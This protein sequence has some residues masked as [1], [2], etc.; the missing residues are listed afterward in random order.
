MQTVYLILFTIINSILFS[1]DAYFDATSES[2]TIDTIEPIIEVFTPTDGQQFYYGQTTNI[3]WNA[4][5]DSEFGNNAVSISIQPEL[6]VELI[7]LFYDIP[8]TGTVN[9]LLPSKGYGGIYRFKDSLW[10]QV[11]PIDD[12]MQRIKLYLLPGN[13]KIV[14]RSKSAKQY[15]YTNE[16][17]FKI[18]SGKSK[19]IKLY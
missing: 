18:Q 9:I 10:E 12:N 15:I 1:E 4:Y 3:Q 7:S 2:F 5:D 6:G 19:L 16:E 8:N 13:Y 17:K 14:F 11:Y